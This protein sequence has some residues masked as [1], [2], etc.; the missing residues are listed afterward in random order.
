MEFVRYQ[1]RLASSS[2]RF[3]GVFATFNGLFYDGRLS[4]SEQQW[5]C[6]NNAWFETH[7]IDPGK[8]DETVFDRT[9]RPHTSSWFRSDAAEF[10]D[11][12]F[13]YL[14]ILDAHHVDWIELSSS[15][16]GPVIYSDHLQVVVAARHDPDQLD[17]RITARSPSEARLRFARSGAHGAHRR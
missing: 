13:R 9:I 1:A 2:G 8:V 5:R 7:L 16:P 6:V 11:R 12:T 4:T 17:E 3:P 15:D 14:D 10:V